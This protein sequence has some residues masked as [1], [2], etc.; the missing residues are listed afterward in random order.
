ME[1]SA[2]EDHLGHCR[3]T[4]GRLYALGC[5]AERMNG[6]VTPRFFTTLVVIGLLI[7]TGSLF[8]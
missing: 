2:L 6:Y 5:L 7:G 3:G 4:N 1:L 8:S